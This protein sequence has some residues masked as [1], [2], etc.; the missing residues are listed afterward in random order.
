VEED[1]TQEYVNVIVGQTSG[2]QR[3]GVRQGTE[4][5]ER[6]MTLLV[7]GI[8]QGSYPTIRL[9]FDYLQGLGVS[10]YDKID[11]LTD[12]RVFAE[13]N[14]IMDGVLA[15]SVWEELDLLIESSSG[16]LI[17]LLEWKPAQV[18]DPSTPATIV[19]NAFASSVNAENS[20]EPS[21]VERRTDEPVEAESTP[22]SE[23]YEYFKRQEQLFLEK[24]TES[25]TTLRSGRTLMSPVKREVGP[26]ETREVAEIL[27]KDLRRATGG[28]RKR[29]A[30]YSNARQTASLHVDGTSNHEGLRKRVGTRTTRRIRKSSRGTRRR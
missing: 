13:T 19:F 10:D 2:G 16:D 28:L 14:R 25:T 12:V 22:P 5:H 24:M 26:T 20:L 9:F 3:G 4:V 27:A 29:R 11:Y 8:E 21:L 23:L 6:A 30:L 1:K 17:G 18:N 7:E 15:E